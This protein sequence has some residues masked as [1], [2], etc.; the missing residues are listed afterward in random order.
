MRRDRLIPLLLAA[1][2][3]ALALAQRPGKAVADTKIDLHVDP[4]GFL[5]DVVSTWTPSTSLGH[6]WSGQYGG[7][8]FPMGPFYALAHELGMSDWVAHRLGLGT[9]YALSAGRTPRCTQII[10]HGSAA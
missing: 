1:G 4:V 7:Y 3:Y 2:C 6:V 5:A 8:L 10:S 9:L